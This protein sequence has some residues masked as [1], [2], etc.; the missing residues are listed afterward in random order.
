MKIRKAQQIL[1]TLAESTRLRIIN[2]LSH[3]DLNVSQICRIID[4]KQPAVSKHLAHLRLVDMVDTKRDGLHVY[5]YLKE[6]A[7]RI[8]SSLVD[9]VTLGLADLET[10]QKDLDKL[11]KIKK[12]SP[13]LAK[14]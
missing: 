14:K 4:K 8:K 2:L 6:P 7:T 3:E 9:A 11:R 13:K 1:K 12:K 10:F 5:Y